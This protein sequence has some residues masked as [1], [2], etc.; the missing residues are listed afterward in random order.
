[1]KQI[2]KGKKIGNEE[3]TENLVF[4]VDWPR[5]QVNLK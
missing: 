1:M 3:K 4:N 2:K 5:L